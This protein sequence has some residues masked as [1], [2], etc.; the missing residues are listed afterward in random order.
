MARRKTKAIRYDSCGRVLNR[1]ESQRK[2]GRYMYQWADSFTG[3]R[4]TVY[5]DTLKALREEEERIAADVH[6]GI[7]VDASQLTVDMLFEAM[8]LKKKGLRE[9]TLR[10]YRKIY[11]IYCADTIGKRKVRDIRPMDI[12]AL[13]GSIFDSGHSGTTLQL[14]NAVLTF[15]FKLAVKNDFIRRNPCEGV[16][17]EF[18]KG[19]GWKPSKRTAVSDSDLTRF[20]QYAESR[21]SVSDECILPVIKVMLLT[22]C[23]VSEVLGLIPSDIDYKGRTISVSRELVRLSGFQD[24]K[25]RFVVTETKTTA[26]TRVVPM[27][28]DCAKAV[29]DALQFRMLHGGHV[30][31]DGV[32]GFIFVNRDG[33]L[34]YH[35]L[36]NGYIHQTVKAF[37]ADEEKAAKADGRDPELIADFTCHKL[38][39]TYAA[40]AVEN[41][42][43]PKLLQAVLGH[44]DMSTTMDVYAEFRTAKRKEAFEGLRQIAKIA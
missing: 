31:V 24:K 15:C 9:N 28:A 16:L 14:V 35:S 36:V 43:N 2:D 1:G 38:R 34:L 11:G 6:D 8:M 10:T 33:G 41:D 39:H 27:S 18:L 40:R 37:N 22:G 7:R 12:E 44:K 20:F 30:T 17:S 19:R 23:R 25:A 26:G 32:S 29:S 13:Y 5:A 4:M 21:A 3:K 42:V